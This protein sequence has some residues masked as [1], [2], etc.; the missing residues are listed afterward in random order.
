M[1]K[2]NRFS[3]PLA[4]IAEINEIFFGDSSFENMSV[5]SFKYVGL[6]TIYR[7]VKSNKC[8]YFFPD[9]N[10]GENFVGGT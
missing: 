4:E 2:N 9:P 7:G 10:E 3:F 1:I 8:I 6:Q 5:D